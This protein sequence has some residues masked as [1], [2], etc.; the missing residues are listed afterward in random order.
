MKS[1]NSMNLIDNMRKQYATLENVNRPITDG[2]RVELTIEGDLEF[3]NV[4]WRVAKDGYSPFT[5]LYD[6]LVGKICGVYDVRLN[7]RNDYR[8]EELQEKRLFSKLTI[9]NIKGLVLPPLD[10]KLPKLLGFKFETL[11]AFENA[12][13]VNQLLGNKRK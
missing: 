3:E 10:D 9:H 11:Q 8:I 13:E 2:D 6:V 7:V 5:N 12:L 4:V 1:G